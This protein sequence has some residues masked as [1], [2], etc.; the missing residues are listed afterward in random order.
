MNAMSALL[1][2]HVH[3][4]N[5]CFPT[6]SCEVNGE[7]FLINPTCVLNRMFTMGPSPFCRREE[8]R[9]DDVFYTQQC[10]LN[11]L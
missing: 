8:M 6:F 3:I 11:T 7:M 2:N 1:A 4:T 10:E 9:R 5:E